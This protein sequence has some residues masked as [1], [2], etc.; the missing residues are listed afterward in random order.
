M[1]IVLTSTNAAHQI[2]LVD[3]KVVYGHHKLL[4]PDITAYTFDEM[5]VGIEGWP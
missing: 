2:S 1:V 4:T 5:L 3:K